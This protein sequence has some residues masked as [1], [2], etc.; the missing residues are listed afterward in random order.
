MM[1]VGDRAQQV[2]DKGNK[3][4]CFEAVQGEKE[5]TSMGEFQK[6]C[7]VNMAFFTSEVLQQPMAQ[8]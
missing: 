7:R 1:M 3:R 2:M 5:V 6:K 8:H 4:M